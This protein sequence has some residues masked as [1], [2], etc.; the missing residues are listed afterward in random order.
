MG[1]QFIMYFKNTLFCI[2]FLR[3]KKTETMCLLPKKEEEEEAV[4]QN[5]VTILGGV[6]PCFIPK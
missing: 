3:N 1:Y 2:K 4:K 6:S 5:K